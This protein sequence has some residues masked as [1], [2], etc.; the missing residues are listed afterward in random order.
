MIYYTYALW[1]SKFDRLYIGFTQDL[2]QRLDQHNQ[3][4]TR[5]SRFY[6]PWQIIIAVKHSSK[7]FARQN[8]VH[9]KKAYNRELLK[10]LAHHGLF[11]LELDGR[12]KDWRRALTESLSY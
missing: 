1:S 5:S 11:G 12:R 4:I 7:S 6:R 2:A 8:E 9:W 3:G 10:S